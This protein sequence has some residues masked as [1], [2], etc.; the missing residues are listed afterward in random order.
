MVA[1]RRAHYLPPN[2]NTKRPVRHLF[3]DVETEGIPLNKEIKEQRL[4]LGYALFWRRRHKRNKDTMLWQFFTDSGTFWDFV[5]QHVSKRETLYLVSH[6]ITFD[7]LVC[8]GFEELEKRGYEL[9]SVYTKGMTTILR[10]TDG[11]YKIVILNNSNW[12]QCTLKSLGEAVGLEKLDVDFRA[13]SDGDLRVYCQR[14]VEIL[15]RAWSMWYE[16]LDEHDLG[17][18]T[19]TLPSQAF[20]AFRHRF[21]KHKL[22]VHDNE[23][24]LKLERTS[25][26][27]GRSSVYYRG[28]N[29]DGPFYKVDINSAYP[30]AML[31]TPVPIKLLF[32]SQRVTLDY[33]RSHIPNRAAIADVTLHVDEN[34]FPLIKDG[35]TVYP[36]GFFRTTLTTPEIVYAL[37]RRWIKTVHS[38][39]FYEQAAI[40]DEY[41][42]F[43]YGLKSEYR[44]KDNE[45]FYYMVKLF[46][47]SLYGKFGQCASNFERFTENNPELDGVTAIVKVEENKIQTVYRFGSTLWIEVRGGETYHSMPAIAAHITAATRL[48]LHQLR[49]AA[50]TRHCYY[51]DT[52]SLI[53]DAVGLSN[54]QPWLDDSEL[55]MLKVEGVSDYIDIRSPK[56]YQFDGDWKRKGVPS[57]AK[58]VADDTW[59]FDAFPSLR[60][61]G[62]KTL[63]VPYWTRETLRTLTYKLYDGTP[64]DSGWVNPVHLTPNPLPVPR[65]PQNP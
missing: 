40:F 41:V 16:F 20:A 17:G 56:T 9:T 22:L 36:T 18:W 25:Y 1:G 28:T 10:V 44:D 57:H 11:D 8:N 26:H 5:M 55:G 50:G 27:G 49:L 4:K 14:D 46:L 2:H 52:D 7:L 24:A 64:D 59:Q 15:Y 34:P 13:V 48:Y 61:V 33:L 23:D 43:F 60:G 19:V 21:M 45:P 47:N 65:M 39:A 37:E 38:A 54:L 42:R 35:H 6:N 30:Y 58:L 29:K 62:K 51:S 53:V 3:F 63:A 32:Y 31:N 12:F